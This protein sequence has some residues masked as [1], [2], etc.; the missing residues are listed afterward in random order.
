MKKQDNIAKIIQ[1]ESKRF[2]KKQEKKIGRKYDNA[3]EIFMR[4]LK[5]MSL[6]F[7]RDATHICV[8]KISGRRSSVTSAN[9]LT[10]GG[11]THV[12]NVVKL[13]CT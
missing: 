5:M 4:A 11:S 9:N 1:K 13:V 3:T 7:K 10:K 12:K 6:M 2:L 8:T